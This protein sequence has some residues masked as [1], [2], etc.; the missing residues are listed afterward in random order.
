MK[1]MRRNLFYW[2]EVF[3]KNF[4]VLLGTMLV[5]SF[6]LAFFDERGLV[7]SFWN[8]FQANLVWVALISIIINSLNSINFY[9]PLT[10]S[11]GST[12]QSSF[13]AMQVTQYLIVIESLILMYLLRCPMEYPLVYVGGALL[14]QGIG[15]MLAVLILRFG[16]NVGIIVFVGIMISSVVLLGIMLI[17]DARGGTVWTNL[18]G[19][20]LETPILLIVGMIFDIL[21]TGVLYKIVHKADL[22]YV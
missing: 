22:T 12:R 9:F 15:Q 10:I 3:E 7:V 5:A 21:F 1:G 18:K 19:K 8:I 4:L 16:R 13:A 20:L 14:L 2:I 6:F 17:V 11:M